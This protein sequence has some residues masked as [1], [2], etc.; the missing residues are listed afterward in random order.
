MLWQAIQGVHL[1]VHVRSLQSR[2]CPE[3][4]V[5]IPATTVALLMLLIKMCNDEQCCFV[6]L[7]ILVKA[8][9]RP[10]HI[11]NQHLP[12]SYFE[13]MHIAQL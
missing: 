9:Q 7:E 3:E 2:H 8:S 6:I 12:I 4:Q 1:S 5:S 10:L 13:I 11:R